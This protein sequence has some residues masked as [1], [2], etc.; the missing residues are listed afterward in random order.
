M[1]AGGGSSP[2]LL[3]APGAPSGKSQ[4]PAEQLL[5]LSLK[6]RPAH[7]T[8]R[9]LALHITQLR[10]AFRSL[11]ILCLQMPLRTSDRA[12]LLLVPMALSVS[13]LT[14]MPFPKELGNPPLQT[15]LEPTGTKETHDGSQEG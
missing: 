7:C 5:W 12:T 6:V 3:A 1:R 13:S 10:A 9:C 11:Q 8:S 4:A 2:V 15:L 14:G